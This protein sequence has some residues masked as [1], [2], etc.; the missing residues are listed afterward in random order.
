[1]KGQETNRLQQ[2]K[3]AIEDA[4][5][6]CYLRQP[7]HKVT[8]KSVVERCYV[9]R[10]TFYCYFTDLSQLLSQLEDEMIRGVS[11]KMD[12]VII[13]AARRDEAGY[14]SKYVAMLKFIS[15]HSQ[16]FKALMFGSERIAF[17]EKYRK[18]IA[19]NVRGGPD[20]PKGH[21]CAALQLP[22]RRRGRVFGKL[23]GNRHGA[24]SRRTCA[25]GIPWIIHRSLQ[26]RANRLN[27]PRA[28]V[29]HEIHILPG[30]DN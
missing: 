10:G 21:V 1:M 17:L 23:A 20:H 7:F 19:H 4:F 15:E 29:Q 24:K 12:A 26:K 13:Q 9:S 16:T 5:V 30:N 6:S 3:T 18:C 25:C 11:E 2:T 14:V 27:G 22:R 8:V 28:C